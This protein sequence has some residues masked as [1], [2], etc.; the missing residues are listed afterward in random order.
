MSETQ[1]IHC[2]DRARAHRENV[3]QNAADAGCRAL[4]RFDKRRV[5]VRF[6]LECDA[7]I[8]ADVHDARVFAR[9]NNNAFACRGQSFQMIARRFLTAMLRPHY[10][11][12][13]EFGHGRSASHYFQ[14]FFVFFRRQSVLSDNFGGDFRFVG[15]QFVIFEKNETDILTF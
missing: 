11:K 10:G 1:G 9:W 5:I 7:P 12:N 2:R 15:H 14:N 8:V 13:S 6:D 3:A 4:K